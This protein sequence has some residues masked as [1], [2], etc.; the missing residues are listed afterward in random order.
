[1]ISSCLPSGATVDRLCGIA[2]EAGEVA[3][4][5]YGMGVEV[6]RKGNDQPVTCADMASHDLIVRRLGEWDGSIPVI[7]EEGAAPAHA[8]RARWQRWWLVDPLD[9]TK[10]FLTGNGE[11]T[12]NIALLEAGE[13]ISE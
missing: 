11:F 7:S 13:P 3:M 1:M 9:G 6:R 4:A 10:E 8:V 12:V 2:R 5:F